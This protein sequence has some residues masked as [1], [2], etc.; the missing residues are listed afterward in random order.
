MASFE[1]LWICYFKINVKDILLIYHEKKKY[2]AEHACKAND[3][4]KTAGS[5]SITAKASPETR[6]YG[7]QRHFSNMAT[8]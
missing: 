7:K 4:K 1:A 8:F 6:P 2:R 5:F 3:I